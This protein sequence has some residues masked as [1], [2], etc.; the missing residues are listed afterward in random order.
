MS[1]SATDH[2]PKSSDSS[3][4][5]SVNRNNS[6]SFT[7]EAILRKDSPKLVLST[8]KEPQEEEGE[9]DKSDEEQEGVH[10]ENVS[11][12][13]D[14]NHYY[15]HYVKQLQH[16]TSNSYFVPGSGIDRNDCNSSN[17]NNNNDSNMRRSREESAGR[18]YVAS[19]ADAAGAR[20]MTSV[21]PI[22]HAVT[23]SVI[24][25]HNH[26]SCPAFNNVNRRNNSTDHLLLHHHPHHLLEPAPHLFPPHHPHHHHSTASPFSLLHHLYQQHPNSSSNSNNNNNHF[27]TNTRQP[28]IS[29]S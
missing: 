25:N 19:N 3:C 28:I 14:H 6:K 23:H 16:H 5:S 2:L 15:Q 13:K 8:E 12:V 9:D 7:V 26:L 21:D 22:P 27:F 11:E 20:I 18:F 17:N 1:Q 10:E 4:V 29:G 24:S